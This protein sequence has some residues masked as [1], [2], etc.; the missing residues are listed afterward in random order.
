MHGRMQLLGSV[1]EVGNFLHCGTGGAKDAQPNNQQS[2]IL[3]L[4]TPSHRMQKSSHC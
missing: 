4:K 2:T 3:I 1:D